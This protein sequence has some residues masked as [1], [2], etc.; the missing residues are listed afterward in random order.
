[1]HNCKTY[2][3]VQTKTGPPPDLVGKEC[4]ALKRDMKKWIEA[5]TEPFD[6][7]EIAVEAEDFLF[8]HNKKKSL[9][10]G[11]RAQHNIKKAANALGLSI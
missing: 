2:L 11:D 6:I 4:A 9:T 5:R 10:E 7:W 8:V 1:M 3:N